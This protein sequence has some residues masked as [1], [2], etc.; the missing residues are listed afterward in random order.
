[1]NELDTLSAGEIVPYSGEGQPLAPMNHDSWTTDVDLLTE[2]GQHQPQ[3]PTMFGTAMPAGTSQQQIDAILGQLGGV[4]LHDFSSLNFP[5]HMI[6]GAISFMTANAT[7]TP[8]HVTKQH[9]FN[10]HGQDDWLGNAFG[11]M[12]HQLSG[13]PRAK[14]SFVTAC[15]KWLAKAS[16]QLNPTEGSVTAPKMAPINS[17]PT[18]NLTDQQYDTLVKHNN[19]VQ[20]QTM[21][22]LQQLWGEYSFQQNIEIAQN[23]LNSLPANE[24]AHFDRYTGSWPWTHFLNSYEGLTGLFNMAIGANSIPRNGPDIAREIAECEKVMRTNRKQWL[25][26]SQLQARYRT[27]LDRG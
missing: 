5:A 13:S 3:G 8:F 14:Q 25:A 10:L 23:H 21:G 1:M 4:F 12:V 27:L 9:S 22:R 24:R 18:A 26:D 6:N 2:R 20:A 7:K 11:N 15:L 19:H 17:D 16:K